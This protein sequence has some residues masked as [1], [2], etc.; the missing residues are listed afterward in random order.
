M[1]SA[2][3]NLPLS[4]K[5]HHLPNQRTPTLSKQLHNF[6]LISKLQNA[7]CSSYHDTDPVLSVLRVTLDSRRFES[8][9]EK[10]KVQKKSGPTAAVTAAAT[11][12]S[13]PQSQS[14]QRANAR[15]SPL[16]LILSCLSFV[17]KLHV[18]KDTHIRTTRLFERTSKKKV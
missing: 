2:E 4:A 1:Q 9:V 15:R 3:C 8:K 7:I 18:L 14:W 5:L 13:A 10:G 6:Y 12:G 11:P 16:V 17:K